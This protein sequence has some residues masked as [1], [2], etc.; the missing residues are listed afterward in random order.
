MLSDNNQAWNWE[1]E[2]HREPKFRIAN[3]NSIKVFMCVCECVHGD[4]ASACF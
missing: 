3:E 4:L 2:K 1:D